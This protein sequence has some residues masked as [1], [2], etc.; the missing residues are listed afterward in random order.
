MGGRGLSKS[1]V[2][3]GLQC[4]KRL[5]LEIN[6]PELA[7]VSGNTQMRFDQ[8]NRLGEVARGLYGDGVLIGH[9]NDLAQA[10]DESRELLNN[11]PANAF[12][13]ATFIHGGVLV[14]ADV[15]QRGRQGLRMVEVKSST[16]LKPQYLQDCAIQAWVIEGAGYP[17]ERIELAHVDTGFVYPGAGNYSSIL[18]HNDLTSEVRM[19]MREV[20]AWVEQCQQTMAGGMPDNGVGAHCK[21]PYDCPFLGHCSP[22][23]PDYP[24]TILPYG[25][26]IVQSLLAEGI[27]DVRDIPV[28]RLTKATHQR[29]HRATLSGKAELDSEAGQKLSMLPY[30]RYYLDF[31]TVQFVVPEWVGT[32]PYEQ[33]PFQWSCHVEEQ[34]GKLH[35]VDFLDTSGNPPMWRFAESLVEALGNDGPILVYNMSFEK[36]RVQALAEVFPDL[37]APLLAV[38]DRMVDLLPIAREHYYHPA[39]KGSWSIKAVLPTIAPQLDY[40]ELMEVQDGTMAQSAYLEAITP[41]TSSERRAALTRALREYCKLDTLAMVKVAH[42][43][44]GK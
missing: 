4:Q 34:N 12:F 30:P 18:F 28:G 9:D 11:S 29:V 6:H 40:Q 1:K 35:H 37:A 23:Q 22:H 8:G 10:A 16:K 26:K 25:G 19:L 13:E 2:M 39:M 42:F 5:Y 44:E 15:L 43:F 36:G 20:P 41:A 38:A 31:E 7:E 33:L 21:T 17:L 27:T 32:R 24:V 14:R 3:S